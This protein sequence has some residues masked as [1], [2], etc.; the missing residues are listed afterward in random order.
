MVSVTYEG[1]LLITTN[2][3]GTFSKADSSVA[4]G[5]WGNGETF[6]C[7]YLALFALLVFD[8]VVIL[9]S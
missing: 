7:I 3:F 8:I 6:Y 1:D 9:R 2:Q 4:Y 5:Y